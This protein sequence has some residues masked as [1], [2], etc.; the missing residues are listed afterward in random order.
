MKTFQEWAGA[1]TEIFEMAAFFKAEKPWK[2]QNVEVDGPGVF[3]IL[4]D[5]PKT[6]EELAVELVEKSKFRPKGTDQDFV[7]L[8]KLAEDN[9][10]D[11]EAVKRGYIDALKKQLRSQ[12]GK[13]WGSSK[14]ERIVVA[15]GNKWTLGPKAEEPMGK[16]G[17]AK[18]ASELL[19][20]GGENEEE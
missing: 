2:L 13:G 9:G 19:D 7:A 20:F 15:P 14:D 11:P 17:K 16:G 10:K 18:K 8:S 3:D 1:N 5:G 6:I 12:K 4:K